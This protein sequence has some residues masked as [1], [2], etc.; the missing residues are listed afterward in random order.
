[1]TVLSRMGLVAAAFLSTLGTAFASEPLPYQ[2]GFQPAVTP[3]MER[4]TSFHNLLLIVITL[5]TLFVLVLLLYVMWRFSEKRNPNP[6]KT[7]HNTLIEVAWTVIP[8]I[9]LVVIAIPSFRLLYFAE[10]VQESD[11]TVKAIGRQWYWSFEYPDHGN[12]TF[13]AN[14]V[15][16]EELQP[17][18]PRLLTTDNAMVLPVDTN[19]RFLITASDVLHNFAMPS[20]ALKTDAVP[21][22]INETWA[23]V[24]ADFAGRTFYGQCSELCGTGHAYMPIMI[25]M[26]TKEEFAAWTEQA[27]EE[28]GSVEEPSPLRLAESSAVTAVSE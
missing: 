10:T 28:F 16:D 17:G 24:P 25:K 6:S 8:I 15:P 9:I 3:V 21:G 14:M 12:F 11:I 1:M 5:I 27:L 2:L 13:D 23:Y 18:Q 26:V 19:I 20:F 4:I 22:R 7:T